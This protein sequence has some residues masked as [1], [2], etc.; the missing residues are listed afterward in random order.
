MDIAYL[1][2]E[3]DAR[4]GRFGL[5]IEKLRAEHAPELSQGERRLIADILE[6]KIK[7]AKHR[8][9]SV[10]YHV[11]A[12]AICTLVDSYK[13]STGLEKAAVSVAA[14]IWGVS[15]ETIRRTVRGNKLRGQKVPTS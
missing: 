7:R 11:R 14:E 5:L 8:P 12:R 15:E 10:P 9:R 3:R 4:D 6:G 1:A 2:A 13:N